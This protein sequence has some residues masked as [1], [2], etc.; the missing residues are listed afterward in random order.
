MIRAACVAAAALALACGRPARRAVA[1]TDPPPSDPAAAPAPPAPPPVPCDGLVTVRVRGVDSAPFDAFSVD[2]AAFTVDG[3][4]TVVSD[5]A[6]QTLELAGADA[7]RVAV[8]RPAGDAP[9]RATLVLAG[10]AGHRID[11]GGAMLDGASAPLQVTVD[12]TKV[13]TTSCHAVIHLDLDG[14]VVPVRGWRAS[15]IVPRFSL[16]Y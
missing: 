15:A 13:S 3:G 12:P 14:S 5:A 4:A 10:G 6:G 16:H 11:G 2:V 1:T 9:F 7:P 8:V